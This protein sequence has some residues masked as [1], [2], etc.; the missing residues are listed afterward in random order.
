MSMSGPNTGVDQVT[1]TT[2]KE[3]RSHPISPNSAAFVVGRVV[4]GAVLALPVVVALG[5]HGGANHRAT[6]AT[7]ASPVDFVAP[8]PPSAAPV[9]TSPKPSAEP[10]ASASS[11]TLEPTP[12]SPPPPHTA[13]KPWANA[14]DKKTVPQPPAA[15]PSSEKPT[16]ITPKWSQPSHSDDVY[17]QP[18]SL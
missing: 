10:T 13:S 7:S 8:A 16:T 14:P 1:P 2:P 3:L 18:R 12:P 5:A 6:S 4:L 17:F 9:P 11:G 15:P